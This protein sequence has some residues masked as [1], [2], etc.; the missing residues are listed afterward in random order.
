MPAVAP[1]PRKLEPLHKGADA[2]VNSLIGKWHR[3]PALTKELENEASLTDSLAGPLRD[4]ATHQLHTRLQDA[5]ENIRR[6]QLRQPQAARE[7]LALLRE[8]ARRVVGLDAFPVQ[9]MGVLAMQRGR[10][11]EMA[12]GEGKTLTAG[13]TAVL[14]GWTGHPCHV[15]TVNDYLVERD[16]QFLRPLLE[17]CGLKAGHVAG[18][19]DPK[20]RAAQYGAHVVW[21]TSKEFAA[22]F[23]RDQLQTGT[24]RDPGRRMVRDLLRR[25]RAVSDTAVQR[26]LHTAI[27][28]EADSLLIDEAVTPLIISTKV[29][30]VPLTNAI[31]TAGGLAERFLHG[32]HYRAQPR[33]K[34]IE[35]TAAGE[36]MLEE[37]IAAMS[38]LW[39]APNRSKELMRLAL[40]AREFYHRGQQYVVED[41][42]VV[43]VDEFTGRPMPDR[44]WRQ[45]L[46]QAVEAKEGLPV[47]SPSDTMARIS[48]QKFFRL[49]R[50]LCGMTGTAQEAAAEFWHVYGLAVVPI[51]PNRPCIRTQAPP[52]CFAH[53]G[54]KIDAIV[55]RVVEIHAT[56]APV[57]VGTRSV[58]S[59]E[60]LAAR[61]AKEGLFTHV[62]NA[63]RIREEA[64][65]VAA[66][67]EPRRVTIA[68]NMAGRGTDIRLSPGIVNLGGL[69]VLSAERSESG[70]VDRQLYGR[71]AR[72]GDPGSAESFASAED[73]LLTRFISAPSRRALTSALRAGLP[74]A[75]PL[76]ERLIRKAQRIAQREASR[77]RRRILESDD[78]L[79][80][81]L[82]FAG[83]D[84]F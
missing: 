16:A 37:C 67:G 66:A 23:L 83:P 5:R 58:R 29:E 6:G 32:T 44:S 24:V 13:L 7:A 33:H 78:W 46:H 9:L 40:S 27:V 2:F 12:T 70:R 82:S 69:H 59:S 81:S 72:Q 84:G 8:A 31:V 50:R 39:R 48:F 38:G 80:S 53:H 74:G 75:Q 55:R 43:I 34:E 52:R 35:F 22:D 3:R 47:T 63:T 14:F 64:M 61:L 45:G 49:Y 28:D 79:E 36:A 42:K 76:A 68:T 62:L 11:A 73:E 26:G 65:I 1:T 21:G 54:D 15:V 20:E 30:N 25:G 41:E 56:G 57:L 10:L 71:C 18:G 17:Y 77:Q 60:E 4:L 51:P 19:M